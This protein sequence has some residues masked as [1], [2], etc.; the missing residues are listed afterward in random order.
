MLSAD[1]TPIANDISRAPTEPLYRRK[2]DPQFSRVT[3]EDLDDDRAREDEIWNAAIRCARMTL[4][5]AGHPA[6]E[7]A[8][9][10]DPLFRV[11]SK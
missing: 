5:K 11:I 6:S 9:L 3:D 10:L 2:Y 1:P 4:A 8:K 7:A